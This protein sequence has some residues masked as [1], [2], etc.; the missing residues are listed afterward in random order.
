MQETTIS[1]EN[2]G[3]PGGPAP[4]CI[5]VQT[6]DAS[7]ERGQGGLQGPAHQ[8]VALAV[9][10]KEC[11]V[12]TDYPAHA[13]GDPWDAWQPCQGSDVAAWEVQARCS[14]TSLRVAHAPPAQ[15]PGVWHAVAAALQG[16]PEGSPTSQTRTSALHADHACWRPGHRGLSGRADGRDSGNTL[17]DS[18]GGEGRPANPLM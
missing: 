3:L 18:T 6:Q 14:R 15:I 4:G 8:R 13:C 17:S 7:L 10:L 9:R 5:L 1:S 11:T 2:N 12:S 16:L